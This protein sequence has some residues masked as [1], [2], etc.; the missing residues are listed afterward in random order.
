MNNTFTLTKATEEV[1]FNLTKRGITNIPTDINVSLLLDYSGSMSNHYS[2]GS[3]IK[4][5]QRLLSIA[6]TIDDD[7]LLELV[8]FENSAHHYG[9]LNVNQYEQ[10]PQIIKDICS[11]YN[12]GGTEFAPPIKKILEI[13]AETVDIQVSNQSTEKPKGFFSKL[14]SKEIPSLSEMITKTVVKEPLTVNG[15]QLLVLISDGENSDKN[16]FNNMIRQIESMPNIYLQCI[17]VGYNSPYLQQIAD[18][19]CSVGYSS[20]S[21]FSKTND[22][23]IN[24]VINSELLSKFSKV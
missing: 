15:K 20:I 3:V 14:F 22:E 4:V 9:T 2:N 13:L 6:N 8:L 7:G 10:V 11:K 24:S 18:Y 17:A 21:D 19:S 5:L 16:L 23:L 1:K 12:M